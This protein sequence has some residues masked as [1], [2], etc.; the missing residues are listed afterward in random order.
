M[1]TE[2]MEVIEDLEVLEVTEATG[3]V[4]ELT[5]TDST[6][7]TPPRCTGT[8]PTTLEVTRASTYWDLLDQVS[9]LLYC[10]KINTLKFN[11]TLT[12]SKGTPLFN[13][14]N[15]PDGLKLTH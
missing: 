6:S 9:I 13:T 15:T 10:N 1:A 4:W 5:V 8:S 7:W 14:S 11:H 12:G 2:D 3:G